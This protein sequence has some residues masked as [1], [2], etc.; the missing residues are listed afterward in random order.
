MLPSELRRSSPYLVFIVT[1]MPS[2]ADTRRSRV[3][4]ESSDA[5]PDRCLPSQTVSGHDQVC[6]DGQQNG[7]D[8]CVIVLR[9]DAYSRESSSRSRGCS[10]VFLP[11]RDAVFVLRVSGL[12]NHL[13][14]GELH[15]CCP[16]TR[17]R[18]PRSFAIWCGG[19]DFFIFLHLIAKWIQLSLSVVRCEKQIQCTRRV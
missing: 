19:I 9:L 18:C 3:L 4:A 11:I 13:S 7:A 2:G 8:T 14:T 15:V 10:T 17:V 6:S 1:P 12:Q 16:E 5:S